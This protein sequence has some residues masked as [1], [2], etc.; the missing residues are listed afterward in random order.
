[1]I[2]EIPA[3][4]TRYT[5]MG[6]LLSSI[7]SVSSRL[8]LISVFW[9]TL[10]KRQSKMKS[11]WKLFYRACSHPKHFNLL[12]FCMNKPAGISVY[13][14]RRVSM[15]DS[16][17]YEIPLE[18]ELQVVVTCHVGAGTWTYVFSKT[19]SIRN[20]WGISPLCKEV[21]KKYLLVYL[22][23]VYLQV[24]IHM[25]VLRSQKVIYIRW[26]RSRVTGTCELNDK[27]AG[28]WIR[29][30]CKSRAYLNTLQLL[31]I[32][33]KICCITFLN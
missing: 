2:S 18:L 26:P 3:V 11:F 17:G 23:D 5:P 8:L 25:W 15:G 21:L 20:Y 28:N 12:L 33:L 13:H 19:T 1:M 6:F 9:G 7:P 29:L 14:V 27:S 32:F 31:K 10:W 30:F 24:N 22:N 4:K 16:R